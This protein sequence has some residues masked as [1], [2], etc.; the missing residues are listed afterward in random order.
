MEDMQ[1]QLKLQEKNELSKILEK[2]KTQIKKILR[3]H[4]DKTCGFFLSHDLLGYI[5]IDQSV[6]P[7]CMIGQTF[8]TRPLLEELFVN[9]EFLLVN[10][11]LYDIKIYKGDFRHL[12]IIQHYEFDQLPKNFS[13]HSSRLYAPEFMGLVPYKSILAMRTIGQKLKDM[14]LYES[15]PVVVTGLEEMKT[16]F[17]RYFDDSPGIISHIHEDFYEKTCM[18]I[19]E[20]SKIFR[21]A[22]TDYYS[23][24]L[25][26]R[27][28]RLT[29]SRRIVSDLG[30]VIRATYSGKV[31]H[32]VIPTEQKIW[33]KLDPATG[34][35]TV[36]KKITKSSVDILNELADEVMKQ[37]GRI[38]ILG[39]HFFPQNSKV[40][41]IL[42]GTL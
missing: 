3:S 33:G 35:F 5:V 42:K 41:A 1:S 32:L 16:F 6:E 11:S 38:Q 17:L 23:G 34:E 13:D 21:Y 8:H 39:P 14:I 9:P 10:V 36:H 18:E 20:R 37:G 19:I 12:E 22:V 27:L 4:P 24:Q 25:K 30:E 29:K 2:N 7:Y 15:M 40:L 28:K 31:G 26:E